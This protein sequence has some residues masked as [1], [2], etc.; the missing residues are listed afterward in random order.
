M[1]PLEFIKTAS[2]G[3]CVSG[4]HRERTYDRTSKV[5]YH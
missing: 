1:M 5:L 3:T 4:C 2:G